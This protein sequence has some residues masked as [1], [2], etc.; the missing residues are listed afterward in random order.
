MNFPNPTRCAAINKFDKAIHCESVK[1]TPNT[2]ADYCMKEDTRIEG[3]W[4]FGERPV[5]RNSKTDWKDVLHNAKIGNIEGIPDDIIVKHY[6]NI[7][8]I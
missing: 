2:A 8:R 3:P 6:G 7:K 4:E 5:Q 1:R